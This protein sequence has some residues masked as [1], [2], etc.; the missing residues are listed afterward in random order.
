MM[1][2][3]GLLRTCGIDVN[4]GK[5]AVWGATAT[6][7]PP[8]LAEEAPD[9]WRSDEPLEERGVR[10]LGAPIG[11]LRYITT[12]GANLTTV[13]TKLLTYTSNLSDLQVAWL[14][15]YYCAVPRLNHILRTT[16]PA[17]IRPL[18]ASHDVAILATFRSI[19]NIP[20][21]TSW[22]TM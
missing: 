18:A 10:V 5:L 8:D 14:L 17:L 3:G 21:D 12:F 9:A 6:A 22:D 15:L 13:R 4:I 19:F 2:P 7:C 16:P 1:F 11:S 20:A